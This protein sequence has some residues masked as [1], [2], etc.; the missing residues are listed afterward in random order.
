M[1]GRR[2]GNVACL[3]VVLVTL[4]GCRA[5]V[6]ALPPTDV[7]SY[8]VNHMSGSVSFVV[9]ADGRAEYEASKP[10]KKP[11]S[12]VARIDPARLAALAEVLAKNDFCGLTS[13]R[14]NGIPDEARPGIQIRTGG[15]DCSVQLWDNE[16]ADDAKA[17]ASLQAVEAF[18]AALASEVDV[19]DTAP[20]PAPAGTP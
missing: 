16:F 6:S 12:V 11:I 18:G 19:R 1:H 13:S 8:R 14:T 10:G 15:L 2:N 20:A 17:R 7:L 5:P 3:G 9:H 4:I